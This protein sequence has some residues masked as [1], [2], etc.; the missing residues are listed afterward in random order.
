MF[1]EYYDY[2]KHQ[3]EAHP[4]LA[5]TST[6]RVY[7][8]VT[9]EAALSD[10]RTDVLDVQGY[11]LRLIEPTFRFS[12]QDGVP[13]K[14]IEG[15]YTIHKYYNR[16]ASG[17]AAYLQAIADTE[18]VGDDILEK[19]I[20]DSEN[21]H[22]LFAGDFS[23]PDATSSIRHNTADAGYVGWL[24]LFSWQIPFGFCVPATRA[25]WTDDGLTPYDE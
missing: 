25:E 5:H 9:L 6:N 8:L 11:L 10:L 21:G 12:G 19:M 13:H 23:V 1:Q 20:A 2:F 15:G 16:Q 17:D 7:S 24:Y 4:S 18:R 22:P 14:L 3:A